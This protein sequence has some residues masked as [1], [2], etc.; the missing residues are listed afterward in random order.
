MFK[1][2]VLLVAAVALLVPV[3]LAGVWLW[4]QV[5]SPAIAQTSEAEYSPAQTITVVGQGSVRV[6]PDIARV[7]VGVET[8]ADAIAEGV[9]D[10]EA[11]MS[12]I[13]AALEAAGIDAKDIQTTNFSISLDRY[14]EPLPR[15]EGAETVDM[16]GDVLDAVIEAG[17]NNIWGVSFTV[18]DPAAAQ[19]D[20]RIDAIADARQRAGAL[21]ELSEVQLGPVMSVSEVISGGSSPV[22]AMAERAVAYDSATIS[23]G[24]LEITYQVQVTYFIE[25]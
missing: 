13:L 6:Q 14:P 20:A 22:L 5:S 21:A 15:V 25:L 18:E 9:T 2:V 10:N 3:G 24:E 12:A 11:Q 19:A 8:T 23:P 4:G 16:V 1:R 7:S 17:A